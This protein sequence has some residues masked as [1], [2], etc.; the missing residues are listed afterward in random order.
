[1]T[2]AFDL[3]GS[4]TTTWR[5]EEV[6][7]LGTFEEDVRWIFLAKDVWVSLQLA[8]RAGR[9]PASSPRPTSAH[10]GACE[11]RRGRPAPGRSRRSATC[12]SSVLMR[13]ALLDP[14]SFTPPYDHGLASALARRGLDV[15]LLT[16]PFAYDDPPA[17]DGYRRHELFLPLS[18]RL[19]R[20]L[21]RSRLRVPLKGLEYAPSVLRFRRRVAV[22]GSGRRPRAVAAA[23]GVRRP[24]AAALAASA[25]RPDGARRGPAPRGAAATRGA[26]RC[27]RST[28]SSCTRSGPSSSSPTSGSRASGSRASPSGLRRSGRAARAAGGRDAALLRAPA[29]VQGARR[30]RSALPAIAERVPDVRLVVAGDPF[31]PDRAACASRPCGSAS[32][33]RS[34]GGSASCATR[35]SRALMG[36][37]AVVVLPYRELDS[38]GVLATALGYGRPA[39]VSDVGLA[40]RDR[41][42]L[43][44]RPRRA[45]GGPGSARC[46][47]ASELLTEPAALRTAYDGTAPRP[48][49]PDL[50]RG[51]R[52][53]ERALPGDRRVKAAQVAPR[54]PRR[55]VPPR[56]PLAALRGHRDLDPAGVRPA[57]LPRPAARPPPRKAVRALQVPHDDPGRDR[58]GKAHG[59]RRPL[60]DPPGRPAHHPQRTLAAPH[61]PRRA[62]A[63]RPTCCVGRCRSSGR[64]P[65]WSSRPPTTPST[66]GGAWRCRPGITGWSQVHGRDEIAWPAADRAGHLVRRQL[67]AP[68]RPADPRLTVGQLGVPSRRP[69][70]TRRTSSARGREERASCARSTRRSGTAC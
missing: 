3:A 64:A 4:P 26:R 20:R 62:A 15:D 18:S 48:R 7:P 17:P 68:A 43:R 39:V 13:I 45:P 24:L 69:S 60:R 27:G 67:V 65:T 38:S 53:H 1:M 10:E 37:T 42:R 46:T 70:R 8:R 55:R 16:S 9:S 19:P 30:A 50:G 66:S 22:A 63:A 36:E 21:P 51:R 29:R 41:G 5:G 52:A 34:S 25:N 23:S 2:R 33:T 47:P 57:R 61:E 56:R 12:A 14:P 44:R 58:R 35:R 28:A 32:T 11:L 54:P 49:G 59:P 31:E 6:E 40:G